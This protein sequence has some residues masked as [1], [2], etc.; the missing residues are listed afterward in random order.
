MHVLARGRTAFHRRRDEFQFLDNQGLDLQKLVLVFLAEFFAA[1]Q[2]DE[3]VELLPTLQI[4]LQLHDKLVQFFVVHK[5][6]DHLGK[7]QWGAL[8]ERKMMA[9]PRISRA[10]I[11]NAAYC[12][13]ISENDRLA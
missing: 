10:V 1:A 9:P 12:A 11:L 6:T 3:V 5:A 2:V 8:G 7:N 4:V 13:T